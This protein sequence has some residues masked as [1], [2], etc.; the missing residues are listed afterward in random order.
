M[1]VDYSLSALRKPRPKALDVADKR[2][3]RESRDERESAK[4]RVRSGGQCEVVMSSGKLA[5]PRCPRRALHVHHILGGI[6]VRGRGL[7][8]LASHKM[9]TCTRCHDEIHR[10]VLVI[11]G[12]AG[13]W[14]FR[15]VT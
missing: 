14:T 2:S 10:H 13:H 1:S 11:E 7:S 8:A 3:A 12:S 5:G 9:H 15:R 6:G 4:V